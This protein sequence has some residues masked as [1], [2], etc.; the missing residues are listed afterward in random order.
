MRKVKINSF[1]EFINHSNFFD[2]LTEQVIFRG[3]PIQG[4]LVPGVGRTLSDLDSTYHEREALNRLKKLGASFIPQETDLDLLVRA[5]HYGLETRLLD[6]TANSL[7]ALWFACA[8]RSH[9]GDVFVYA[10]EVDDLMMEGIDYEKDPFGT[11]KTRAFQPRL[12]NAR[13]TAQD[14]WFTLHVYSRKSKRF[15]PLEKNNEVKNFLHEFCIPAELRMEMLRALDRHGVSSRTLFPDLEGLCRYLNWKR[16]LN[17]PSS[18][19]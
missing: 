16:T 10:L 4:D 17:S 3:Q 7:A 1:V 19:H 8:D 18:A 5:Q 13:V 11:K 12:N 14:G 2:I 6:W 9:N 15:V